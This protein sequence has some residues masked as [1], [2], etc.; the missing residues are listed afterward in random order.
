MVCKNCGA[1]VGSEYRLCPYCRTELEYPENKE[2]P[3]IN[4]V[5][6]NTTNI[7]TGSSVPNVTSSNYTKPS[8]SSPE[9]TLYNKTESPSSAVNAMGKNKSKKDRMV[10]LAVCVLFG[11]FGAHQFYAGNTAMGFIYLFTMGFC[12]IGG[13]LI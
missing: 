3:I 6:N 1:N 4:T 2:Q 10:A 12:G 8:Y 9:D 5:V 7:N 13:L 11:Y